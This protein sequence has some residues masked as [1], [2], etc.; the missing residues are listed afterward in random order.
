M[1]RH[2]LPAVALTALA[3][4]A[5]TAC[6]SLVST[7]EDD[8]SP[9][10]AGGSG[11]PAAST[12][13]LGSN[14]WFGP[15]ALTTASLAAPASLNR[16]VRMTLERTP[17]PWS[18]TA[19]GA[20]SQPLQVASLASTSCLR[21]QYV[22]AA[23]IGAYGTEYNARM[24]RTDSRYL[25]SVSEFANTMTSSLRS[26]YGLCSNS[27]SAGSGSCSTLR[28]VSCDDLRAMLS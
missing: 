8:D 7:E 9:R 23:M 22:A 18:L 20:G 1:K 3:L 24:A 12:L 13:T 4:C 21:D 15:N 10:G 17:G 25:A 6:E 5:A 14:Q 16:Q 28:Y 11:L 26:A 19:T 27:S 2:R